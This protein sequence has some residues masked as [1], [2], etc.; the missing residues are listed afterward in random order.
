MGRYGTGKRN[1]NGESLL[2]FLITNDLFAANTAFKHPCRHRTTR[3]GCI[4]KPGRSRFSSETI[5]TY[6]QIDFIICRKK[7]K[8][9]L[10]NARSYEHPRLELKSDHRPVIAQIDLSKLV[11][12][13]KKRISKVQRIDVAN[14]VTDIS[15][16]QQ[17]IYT[18]LQSVQN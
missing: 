10:K 3:V 4:P 16:K 13:H 8:C 15:V 7:S 2:N 9:L 12:V 17:Y 5:P 11:L 6:V 1:N 14:L 18:S